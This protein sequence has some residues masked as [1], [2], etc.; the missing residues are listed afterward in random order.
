MTVRIK[1]WDKWQTYR[2]DRGTPPWIKI[3]RN[4]LSN[5]DWAEL[6]DAEK[7]QL[8]S[9][10][11]VAA[12]KAGALPDDPNIIRKICLLDNTPDLNKL[13]KLGFIDVTRLSKRRQHDAPETEVETEIE[14]EEKQKNNTVDFEKLWKMYPVRQGKKAAHR[15]F[16]ATV[17][18][19]ED[20]QRILRAFGNYITH[21]RVNTWKRAMNGSTWFNNWNDWIDWIEP[22]V[23]AETEAVKVDPMMERVRNFNRGQD[24][25]MAEETT[26]GRV[27]SIA[28]GTPAILPE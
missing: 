8:V 21:L 20:G 6:S 24:N 27:I 3:H 18:T 17:K 9:M 25:G 10:W 2:S 13:K 26:G 23:R 4:L 5:S 1:N 19:L 28:D 12:D 14:V 7:G 16:D 15:H 11:I 22:E